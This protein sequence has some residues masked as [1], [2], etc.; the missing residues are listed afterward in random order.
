[1]AG[2]LPVTIYPCHIQSRLGFQSVTHE[3][4]LLS[5]LVYR[6]ALH[7]D[8]RLSIHM[9][10]KT[11]LHRS[12]HQVFLTALNCFYVSRTVWVFSDV[13]FLICPEYA[14]L[15]W[16][17]FDNLALKN[18][19]RTYLIIIESCTSLRSDV[20]RI[21]LVHIC[22]DFTWDLIWS[23][24]EIARYLIILRSLFESFFDLFLC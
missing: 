11:T 22:E 15:A 9:I 8:A 3:I 14:L 6:C 13:I 23:Q 21:T 4:S 19:L 5:L 18:S 10:V 7:V 17:I 24:N 1:M 2:F 20:H 16:G 12:I